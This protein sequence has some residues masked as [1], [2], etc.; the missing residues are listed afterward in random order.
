M[1]ETIYLMDI[2]EDTVVDG[3]GFRVSVY[4]AGCAHHCKGCHNPSSWNL[5][6]GKEVKISSI[7]NK[8][9][10]SPYNVTLTGG[11][12]FYQIDKTITLAKTIK[13][14]LNKNIWCYTG[15]RYEEL[16]SKPSHKELLKYIDI[17]VDGKFMNDMKDES[18]LFRGSA[19]QRII[20]VKESFRNNKTVIYKYDPF[21][22]F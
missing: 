6:S 8:I 9:S 10:K 12:P 2:V 11:D 7:I 5:N 13:Q 19:N 21:P 22:Q 15:Y 18:L 20:D 3:P 17:L 16:L 4:L 14:D 1:D